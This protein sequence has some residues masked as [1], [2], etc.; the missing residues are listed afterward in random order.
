MPAAARRR[1]SSCGLRDPL[2]D[3]HR[4]GGEGAEQRRVDGDIRECADE[5][6]RRR[7]AD[8]PRER[9]DRPGRDAGDR[10][11]QDLAPDDLPLRGTERVGALADRVRHRPDRLPACHD[12][13]GEHQQGQDEG[14]GKEHAPEADPADEEGEPEDAVDDRRNRSQVLD[15]DLEQLVVPALAI[16]VLLEVERGPDPDGHDEEEEEDHHVDGPADR[17]PRACLVR[18]GGVGLVQ[19]R[20][21]DVG[22]PLPEDVDEEHG[23]QDEADRDRDEQ[24][25]VERSAANPV[26]LRATSEGFG[27]DAHS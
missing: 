3:L 13:G 20:R 26:A 15:V 16:R 10:G 7:L 17:G 18:V 8:R 14:S 11:G 27:R 23:E 5:Q 19:E 4:Q 1:N 21:V 24:Q 9:E 22:D 12:H 6:K 2:V 25:H